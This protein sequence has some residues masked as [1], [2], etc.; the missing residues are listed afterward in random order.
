MEFLRSKSVAVLSTVASSGQ[1]MSA[2]VYF[3]VDTHFNFYFMTK[4]FSRKYEN[5]ESNP[6]V[7]LVVGSE[8]EPVTAQVQ[9]KAEK[10]VDQQEELSV[11]EELKKV[12]F[13]N[14]YV[15]PLYQ[16]S[17]EKNKMVIYKITPT[18]VRWLDLRG[19]KVN[20]EFVQILP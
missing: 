7:A 8:N 5:L 17:E 12:F 14:T 16:L 1:P 13:K 4:N 9:G 19:E 15:A 6:N 18:W 2:A 11:L 20:G 10:I 3:T